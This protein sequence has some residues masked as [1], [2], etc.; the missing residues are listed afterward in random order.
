MKIKYY[1]WVRHGITEPLLKVQ[2]YKKVED[3]K[4]VAMYDIMY[5]SNKLIT[6]YE[7]STLD[8]PVIV[9]END[10]VN[11]ANV[12][13]LIRK[14]YDEANDDLIIRGERYLGEKLIELIA[15]EES[16]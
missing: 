15:L 3:G 12:L 5:Y 2:V 11:L 6:V 7:N 16:E 10:E 14:Y 9:E 1:E 8:G 13:K 4:I